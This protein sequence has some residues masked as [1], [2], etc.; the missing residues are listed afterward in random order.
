MRYE[1][2]REKERWLQEKRREI[3]LHNKLNVYVSVCV[4]V[5]ER[6]RD[7]YPKKIAWIKHTITVG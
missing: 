6:E 7:T 3:Y 4:C 1:R 2:D 5:R